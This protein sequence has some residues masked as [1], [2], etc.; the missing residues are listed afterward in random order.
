MSRGV[1]S[2]DSQQ[3]RGVAEHGVAP[4]TEPDN[5]EECGEQLATEWVL[6]RSSIWWLGK[7][8]QSA[9]LHIWIGVGWEIFENIIE[10]YGWWRC[11]GYEMSHDGD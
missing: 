2:L 10:S 7:D 8:L 9:W 11:V 4:L 3:R 6:G 5:K 1:E